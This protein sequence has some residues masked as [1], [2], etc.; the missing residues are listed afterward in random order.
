MSTHKYIH[1][2]ERE[3]EKEKEK[4]SIARKGGT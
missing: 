4:E 3:K 2:G 1:T